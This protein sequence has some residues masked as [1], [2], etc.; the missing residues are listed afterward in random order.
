ME[1]DYWLAYAAL[2]MSLPLLLVHEAMCQDKILG[3]SKGCLSICLFGHFV[4]H[5]F[6][7]WM[8]MQMQILVLFSNQISLRE[9]CR[10]ILV[11][12]SFNLLERLVKTQRKAIFLEGMFSVTNNTPL[13]S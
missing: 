8:M 1:K 13:N 11:A 10:K 3:K 2:G 6:L 12:D 9:G 4:F 7:W 5:G